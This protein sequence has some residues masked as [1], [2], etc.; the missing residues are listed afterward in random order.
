MMA[1]EPRTTFKLVRNIMNIKKMFRSRRKRKKECYDP[2]QPSYLLMLIIEPSLFDKVFSYLDHKSIASLERT[3][4]VLRDVVMET[5]IYRRRFLALTDEVWTGEDL[6]E[7]TYEQLVQQSCKYKNK[8]F[9]HFYRCV[10][11]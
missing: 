3:C 4:T 7:E 10:I 5:R 1:S 8:L 6:D 2:D 9:E 11:S